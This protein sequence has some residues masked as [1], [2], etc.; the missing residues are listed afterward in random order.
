ME[1][2]VILSDINYTKWYPA[3][4]GTLWGFFGTMLFEI[5]LIQ[6]KLVFQ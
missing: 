6:E 3:A 4:D 5:Y 2:L 1:Q